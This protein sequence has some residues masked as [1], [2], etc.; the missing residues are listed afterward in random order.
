MS[1]VTTFGL[2]LGTEFTAK[3]HNIPGAKALLS[4]A[5]A[6][7]RAPV[8]FPG[9]CRHKAQNLLKGRIQTGDLA[10]GASS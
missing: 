5:E 8:L 9:I 4:G 7:A 3:L 2:A 1:C 6:G 10:P